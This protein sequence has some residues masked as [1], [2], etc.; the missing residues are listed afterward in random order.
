MALVTCFIWTSSA[1]ITW[2][3]QLVSLTSL[4]WSIMTDLS[5]FYSPSLFGLSLHIIFVF[6][7]SAQPIVDVANILKCVYFCIFLNI[8]LNV[9]RNHLMLRH[10][11]LSAHSLYFQQATLLL[12]SCPFVIYYSWTKTMLLFQLQ[13]CTEMFSRTLQIMYMFYNV[14]E[15]LYDV[16]ET[17]ILYT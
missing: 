1:V 3:R 9:K 17:G 12:L 7:D 14:F 15:M 16:I 11:P 10:Q 5:D 4:P 8:F 6:S 2:T 13:K